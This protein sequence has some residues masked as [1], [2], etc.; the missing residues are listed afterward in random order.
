[1]GSEQVPDHPR[2]NLIVPDIG[3]F[4]RAL[5]APRRGY[6]E[7]GPNWETFIVSGWFR[8]QT[9]P[10]AARRRPARTGC[11]WRGAGVPRLSTWPDTARPRSLRECPTSS[12]GGVHLGE[13]GFAETG[14]RRT[15]GGAA[16]GPGGRDVHLAAVATSSCGTAGDGGEAEVSSKRSRAEV[17]WRVSIIGGGSDVSWGDA[18]RLRTA[19]ADSGD[20]E[21]LATCRVDLGD[22][23]AAQEAAAGMIRPRRVRGDP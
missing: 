17:T 4:F 13:P 6:E 14:T 16:A 12:S 21:L 5:K 9:E 10:A 15:V 2:T 11:R 20:A 23:L 22:T 7:D 8:R 3:E 18:D 19:A 1:M